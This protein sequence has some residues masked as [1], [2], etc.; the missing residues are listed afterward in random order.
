MKR[1]SLIVAFLS[2]G[3]GLLATMPAQQLQA[4]LSTDDD[5]VKVYGVKGTLASGHAAAVDFQ[6]L[7]LQS[8]QWSLNPWGLLKAR[9]AHDV[10]ARSATGLVNLRVERGI[11]GAIYVR[12]ATGSLPVA[13]LSRAAKLPIPPLQGALQFEMNSIAISD[14][15]LQHAEGD[16]LARGLSW[17]LAT[18]PILLGNYAVTLHTDDAGLHAQIDDQNASLN[19]KGSA[20]LNP[21]GAYNLDI[22]LRP[23]TNADNRIGNLLAPLGAAEAGGWNRLKRS[24]QLLAPPP[25]S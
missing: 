16:L 2:F 10:K 5:P 17:S 19:L 15:R 12:H 24:G 20:S 18:P 8:P 11:T 23:A 6:G 14:N 9:L 7:R 4:W 13:E 21:E 25:A 3:I 1:L 22:K